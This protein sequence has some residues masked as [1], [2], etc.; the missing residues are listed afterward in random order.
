MKT[1]CNLSASHQL[2]QVVHSHTT[3]GTELYLTTFTI[4]INQPC[5][6]IC[7]SRGSYG[8]RKILI[9]SWLSTF[10]HV[11]IRC[12]SL[13][14]LSVALGVT[15]HARRKERQR[16]SSFRM[17]TPEWVH[18]RKPNA[19]NLEMNTMAMPKKRGVFSPSFTV[20]DYNPT[21]WSSSG[22]V[23]LVWVIF[24]FEGNISFVAP[25]QLRLIFLT[26]SQPSHNSAV[27]CN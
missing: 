24:V 14:A 19:R 12:A 5:R 23:W 11:H 21:S 7:S 6:Y 10:F 17:S 27:L 3:H 9:H 1:W 25:H 15:R 13:F 4:K 8:I 18:P 2:C 22:F 26:P 16:K 20:S